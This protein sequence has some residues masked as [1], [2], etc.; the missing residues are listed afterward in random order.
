VSGA[1]SVG[2]D[3]SGNDKSA[4]HEAA[5]VAPT[6]AADPSSVPDARITGWRRFPGY[7][8]ALFILFGVWVAVLAALAIHVL[9]SG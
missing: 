7:L 5:A 6:S 4:R 8:K 9:L 1:G 2:R 3:K